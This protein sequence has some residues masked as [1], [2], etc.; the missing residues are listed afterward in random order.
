MSSHKRQVQLLWREKLGFGAGNLGFNLYWTTIASFLAA[1]Y[2]DVSGISAAAAR[3]MLFTTKIV[4]TFTDPIMGGIAVRMSDVC[5]SVIPDI[6][7]G[8]C[9]TVTVLLA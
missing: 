2:T 1:F 9:Y 8:Q 5:G 7:A 4:D 3:T 6:Q